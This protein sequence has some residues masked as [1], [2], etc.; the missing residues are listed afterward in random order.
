MVG[1]WRQ[2]GIGRVT[3]APPSIVDLVAE[4]I[5][6]AELAALA[7]LLTE[8]GVPLTV[9]GTASLTD[10]T[11]VAQA[12]LALPPDTSWVLVDADLERPGLATL[13]ARI[14]GGVRVGITL[15]AVDLRAAFE[16]LSAAPDGLPE[17]AVR[18][19]GVVLVLGRVLST[20]IGPI[21]EHLRVVAA[22]YLRPIERDVAGH[23]QRRP[24]AVLATWSEAAAGFDHFAWGL[25][26]ELAD[27]VDR[28]Q[29]SFEELQASR[30]AAIRNL[31]AAHPGDV[32]TALARVLAT[33]PPRQPATVRPA[34]AAPALANPLTDPHI[35]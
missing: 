15:E 4:G 3:V 16:R 33:E 24:P 10:R 7:W 34:A 5:I 29:A 1:G 12:V 27:L 22:H 32:A 18:R 35:H 2:T 13:G 23:V 28:T 30:A 9:T 31:T 17:D 14:R 26:P 19:L 11:R 6:D 25:T 8:G 20:E 21:D